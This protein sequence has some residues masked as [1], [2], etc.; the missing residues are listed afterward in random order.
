[1]F[2]LSLQEMTIKLAYSRRNLVLVAANL[3]SEEYAIGFQYLYQ[4]QISKNIAWTQFQRLLL[5]LT[6]RCQDEQK[7]SSKTE[8]SQSSIT[9]EFTGLSTKTSQLF[10]YEK[11]PNNDRNYCI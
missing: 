1:M 10:L 9:Q 7:L 6:P 4:N 5:W 11:I 3:L 8:A 2:L